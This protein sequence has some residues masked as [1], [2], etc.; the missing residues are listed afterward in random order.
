MWTVEQQRN[1]LVAARAYFPDEAAAAIRQSG[2]SEGDKEVMLR[3]MGARRMK[4]S[5]AMYRMVDTMVRDML[6]DIIHGICHGEDP[7]R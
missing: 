7:G 4:D 6:V 5:W 1:L 3:I 2:A